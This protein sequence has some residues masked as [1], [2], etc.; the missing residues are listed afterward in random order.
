MAMYARGRNVTQVGVLVAISAVI[1]VGFF[2]WLTG[3]GLWGDVATLYVEVPTAEGLK[4]GDPV[5]YRGVPVGEV[6]RLDFDAGAGVV[7]VASL[8]REI[9]LTGGATAELTTV[10]VFGSQAVLFR[11]GREGA[12]PV[13]DGDTV[14]GRAPG[15][16]VERADTLARRIERLVGDTTQALVRGLLREGRDASV[17]LGEV[18]ARTG[19]LLRDQSDEIRRTTANMASLTEKLDDAAGGEELKRTLMSLERSSANLEE[20]TSRLGAAADGLASAMRK[21]NEGEGTAGRLLTDPG[22]YDRAYAVLGE[23]DALLKDLREDPDRY[24]NLSIF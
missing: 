15:R 6:G 13:E 16:L 4:K 14:P 10:D 9:P 19:A 18:L 17:E 23:L 11:D 1:F 8:D 7:A 3:R 2:L 20:A 12:P 21:L 24:V 22:L 5:L